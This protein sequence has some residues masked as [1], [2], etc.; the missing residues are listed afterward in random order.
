M[1]YYSS[2]GTKVDLVTIIGVL[3][4]ELVDVRDICV[5][6][7]H[8]MEDTRSRNLIHSLIEQKKTHL[9]ELQE[10]ADRREASYENFPEA[11]VRSFLDRICDISGFERDMSQLDF[12]Q[13]VEQRLI[14][15]CEFY[16]FLAVNTDNEDSAYTFRRLEE[17]DRKEAALIRDRFDLLTLSP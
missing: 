13:F 3:R 2:G 15:F 1:L 4:S 17:E 6:Y 16:R 5:E 7:G 12:L 14:G 9:S 8:G 11:E 10:L